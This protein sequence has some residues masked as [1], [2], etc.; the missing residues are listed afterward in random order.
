M[1]M[2]DRWWLWVVL[3]TALCLY[4]A[5]LPAAEGAE[6]EIVARVNGAPIAR[7]EFEREVRLATQRATQTGKGLDEERRAALR[8]Q[9]LEQ[10][11]GRELLLQASQENKIVVDHNAVDGKLEDIK[12]RF[13]SDKEYQETLGRMGLSEEH[14]KSQIRDGLTIE[15]LIETEIV[16]KIVVSEEESQSFYKGHPELFK[17]AEQVR[18]SHILVKIDAQADE[19]TRGEARKKIETVEQQ[20]QKGQDFATLAKDFS[21]CPSK[22][23]GGDLGYFTRGK[24]VKPFED[25]AFGLKTGEVSEIVETQF[26]YHLIKV[27]DRKPEG[28]LPFEE[29]KEKLTAYLTRQR[30]Q[31]QVKLYVDGLRKKATVE[32]VAP[33]EKK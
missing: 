32:I 33:L 27:T 30:V 2:S 19:A 17:A 18:A 5:P 8:Q 4:G 3:L 16:E 12:K 25:A 6:E 31:E 24:M 1:Y 11:I 23:Q 7:A 9:T 28:I 10:L 29:V 15:R 13:P 20:L 22:A 26:G 21:D 14:V